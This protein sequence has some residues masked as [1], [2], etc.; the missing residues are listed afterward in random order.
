MADEQEKKQ[1]LQYL[2][3]K[4]LISSKELEKIYATVFKNQARGNEIR[5]LIKSLNDL[6]KPA[7]LAVKSRLCE[8]NNDEYFA[9]ISLIESE[10]A[11]QTSEFSAAELDLFK[12][13]MK[14]I[15]S[16]ETGSVSSTD[17][18]NHSADIPK[19]SKTDAQKTLDKFFAAQW[20]KER[21]GEVSFTVRTLLEMEPVLKKL[22][23]DL[24]DCVI[25]NKLAVKKFV[26][27]ETSCGAKFHRY[28]ISKLKLKC[29]N[30]N[31]VLSGLDDENNLSQ[32]FA[33]QTLSQTPSASSSEEPRRRRSGVRR[34]RSA[35]E[36]DSD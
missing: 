33:S 9:L 7:Q 17:C 18:I 25:C 6:L 5:D 20:L 16:S 14:E 4:P 32:T 15:I 3:Y 28:C 29:P 34:G 1:V 35:V 23:D 27:P 12:W 19:L 21:E 31:R 36:S 26:C 22:G 24:G 8:D 11:K 10:A 2:L 30:C 13:I